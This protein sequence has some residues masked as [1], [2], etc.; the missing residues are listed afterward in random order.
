M[1]THLSCPWISILRRLIFSVLV[2]MTMKFATSIST[3]SPALV[4]LRF[5]CLILLT[6]LF[7]IALSLVICVKIVFPFQCCP[8]GGT[9]QV[10]FQPRMGHLLAAAS[11]KVVSIFDVETDRQLHSFQVLHIFIIYRVL[12]LYLRSNFKDNVCLLLR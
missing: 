2:I 12:L 9:A 8:Q 7:S 11:D 5:C 10:R 1:G 3:H 4:F 6:L